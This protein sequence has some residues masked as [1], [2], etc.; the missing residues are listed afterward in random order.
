MMFK[1]Y[2]DC[3]FDLMHDSLVKN[4]STKVLF[5]IKKKTSLFCVFRV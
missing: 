2:L 3:Q 5:S 4:P 1:L